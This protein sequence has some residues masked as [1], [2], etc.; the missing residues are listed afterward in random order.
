[1][2]LTLTMS[3]SSEESDSWL[4]SLTNRSNW[5][6][7]ISDVDRGAKID[8]ISEAPSWLGKAYVVFEG[9]NP[10][11]YGTWVETFAEVKDYK[12]PLFE[13]FSSRSEAIKAFEEYVEKKRSTNTFKANGEESSCA[14][15]SSSSQPN[16]RQAENIVALEDTLSNLQN[17]VLQIMKKMDEMKQKL[18][19]MRLSGRG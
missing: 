17:D 8:L 7:S 10:G 14:T 19:E 6:G 2:M 16:S 11:V 5:C 13:K 3:L 1:M 12:D 9:V 4:L 15:S 18:E